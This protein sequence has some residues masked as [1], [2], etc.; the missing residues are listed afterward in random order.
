MEKWHTHYLPTGAVL[1][2]AGEPVLDSSG[3]LSLMPGVKS[4]PF[5]SGDARFSPQC[6]HP[7]RSNGCLSGGWISGTSSNGGG[8]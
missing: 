5:S 1:Q 6:S 4:S 2:H 8:V 7:E 3:L